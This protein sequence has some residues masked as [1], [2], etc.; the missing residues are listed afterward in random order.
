MICAPA[1][2]LPNG[3][4]Y[5]CFEDAVIIELAPKEGVH[6]AQVDFDNI[7]IDNSDVE[8]LDRESD[9]DKQSNSEINVA[10]DPPSSSYSNSLSKTDHINA[11]KLIYRHNSACN[12]SYIN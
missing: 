2:L 9:F 10:I 3:D 1:L 12:F 6:A 11:Q 4:G 5:E 8:H 7:N